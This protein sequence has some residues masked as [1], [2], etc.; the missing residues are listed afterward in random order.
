MFH[1]AG[2]CFGSPPSN[3]WA[4]ER[5]LDYRVSLFVLR[6]GA[7]PVKLGSRSRWQIRLDTST[8]LQKLI[9]AHTWDVTEE[10]CL[11]QVDQKGDILDFSFVSDLIASHAAMSRFIPMFVTWLRSNV[12]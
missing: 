9:D 4:F 12:P 7:S 5:G 10:L 6:L 8:Q 11:A 2:G 3:I 1:I